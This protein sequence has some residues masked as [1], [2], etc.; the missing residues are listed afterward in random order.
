MSIHGYVSLKMKC[1]TRS[2]VATTI[3]LH[4]GRT[5]VTLRFLCQFVGVS[6]SV[7]GGLGMSQWRTA[8]MYDWFELAGLFTSSLP[9]EVKRCQYYGQ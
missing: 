5:I 3:N 8:G 2:V 6:L 9:N 7:W 1:V 4:A